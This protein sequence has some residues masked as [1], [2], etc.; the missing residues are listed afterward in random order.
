V[1]PVAM[2]VGAALYRPRWLGGLVW[3]PLALLLA[4]VLFYSKYQVVYQTVWYSI[5]PMVPLT[6]VFGMLILMHGNDKEGLSALRRQQLM[7]LLSLAGM[8]SLVQFPFSAPVYFLYIAPLVILAVLAI[9][10]FHGNVGRSFM[11][12]VFGFYLIFAIRWVNP[13]FIYNMGIQFV[14]DDQTEVLA[15][16]RG[17]LRV[18]HSHKKQYEKLVET[19]RMRASG[20]FTY[21]TPD[22]PEVYFLAALRNPTRTI[23]EFLEGPSRRTEGVV[24]ILERHR[25]SAITLNREPNFSRALPADLIEVLAKR[26]PHAMQIGNFEVRWIE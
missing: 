3:I 4:A 19:L 8:C 15:L 23:F 25:V 5:R 20:G 26:F 24:Q 9:L 12:T 17:G 11:A 21:A 7:L 18:S 2:L 16:D 6:I 13:G 22:C 1:L 14:P 10:S